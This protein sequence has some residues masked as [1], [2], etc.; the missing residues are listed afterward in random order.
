MTGN[1]RAAYVPTYLWQSLVVT[2]LC[3]WPFGIPAII[4][5]TKVS[6]HLANGDHARALEASIQARMWCII[7]LVGGL[8]VQCLHVAVYVIMFIIAIMDVW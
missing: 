3:C 7:A 4:N 6:D 2:L 1:S 8:I 5:A